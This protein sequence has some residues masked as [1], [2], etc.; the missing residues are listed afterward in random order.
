[1]SGNLPLTLAI[2]LANL[3]LGTAVFSRQPRN[4]INRYFG[5]FSLFVSLWTFSSGM[6]LDYYSDSQYVVF[7]GR[8]T[9]ASAA[10]I[11]VAFLLFSTVFPA[12]APSPFTQVVRGFVLAGACFAGASFSPLVVRSLA[13]VNGFLRVEYGPLH[14]AYGIYWVSC[15]S[16]GLFLLTQKLPSLTGF[17]KLQARYL[18]LAVSMAGLGAMITNLAIP[19][20]F[21]S[22]RLSRYGP[23]FGLLMMAVIAHSII[24]HRLMHIRFV[25]KRGVVYLVAVAISGAVFALITAV[26]SRFLEGRHQDVPLSLQVAVALAIALAFQPLK[27]RL[28]AWLDRYVYRET[29]DY[30]RIIRSASRRIGAT[31][32]LKV[33]L[34]YL[35]QVTNDSL[36]PDLV[37][38]FTREK[39]STV[40]S[41]AAGMTM[42][43]HTTLDEGTR[44][45]LGTP[46]PQFLS[47]SGQPLLKDEL[48]RTITGGPAEAAV[49]HLVAC[50]GDVV[51]PMFSERQLIGFLMVGSKLSGDVYAAEDVELLSTLANQTAIAV[52]NAQLY[53]QVL[54]A[55]EYIENILRTMDSGVITVD[56]SGKVAL[57]NST[58]EKLTG[59]PR[60][61]LSS[62]TIRE[63]PLSLGSQL[64][65]T[66][67]DGKPRLQFE[68]TLPT[69]SVNLIPIVCSTSALTDEHGTILGA[70]AVFTDL[71]K[72]KALENEKRRAERLAAFGTLVSG[73]AHEIKNPLVAIKTFA[74]LLPERYAEEDF[75]EDFAKVVINE[76]DRIDDLVARLRGLAAPKPPSIG[77]VDIREPIM[78][79]LVLLRAQIEQ[80][81]TVLHRE[82]DDPAPLVVIDAAQLK[83]L[84]LNIFLNAIEAMGPGGTLTV[85]VSRREHQSGQWIV[86]EVSDTGPGIPESIRSSIFDPFFTTKPRGSGLGLAICR[87]I[88][89]AHKG[90]IRA[91]NH[92]GGTSIIVEFPAVSEAEHLA[93]EH[94]LRS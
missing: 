61:L 69:G 10:A 94:V 47:A 22:S 86:G 49:R 23:L 5:L 63:L 8:L 58:A 85:R 43:E 64:Q 38:V 9:F 65:A 72:L 51:V 35:C 82:F 17:Q 37:V 73:I 93:E 39:N 16:L 18:F 57:S 3:V 42:L 21:G 50:G 70:L 34:Q 1:M 2:A 81:Q 53:R 29:Y 92:G 13:S 68:T 36:K 52:S 7:F 87:G 74:E 80:T 11:P 40:F 46:L 54:I 26:T 59:I 33:L 30:Q 15:L 55:N 24:R 75:R 91:E 4:P 62:T 90:T 12:M 44:F 67:A 79:T 41:V 20:V 25:A 84:F 45:E 27:R 6:T 71:S 60:T 48:G 76:I 19:L 89:D 14:L 56:A 88:M 28:Q 66:M 31:L 83:Q 78:D 77:P 32:D